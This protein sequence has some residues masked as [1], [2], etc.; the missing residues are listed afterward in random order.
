MNTRRSFLRIVAT[1]ATMAVSSPLAWA[2]RIGGKVFSP[3]TLDGYAQ[4]L[5]SYSSLEKH[6]G[7]LF[8]ALLDDDQAAYM[9]LHSVRAVEPE[10]KGRAVKAR[11][12]AV[13][14]FYTATFLTGGPAIPQSTY[15][16]DHARLGRN[17]VFLVPGI[18]QQGR[19][20]LIATF[21]TAS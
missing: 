3:A 8:M 11:T 16:L 2:S 13:P 10:T 1:A 15:V 18:D 5:L 17:A 7:S 14:A 20:L 12:A 4:G 21:A 9:H 19:N 6:V